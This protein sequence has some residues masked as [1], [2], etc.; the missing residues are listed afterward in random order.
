MISIIAAIGKNR[1]LGKNN[2]LIFRIKEDMAFFKQ[3]TTGHAV[4]MGKKTFDSIGHPLPNRQ[5][6]IITH[7]PD[8]LPKDVT[9]I[10]DLQKF[11]DDC[12]STKDEVF[13]IGGA[14]IYEA[15][16]PYATN[17]Y[18]T[19]VDAA[20]DADAFFPEFNPNDYTREIIKKG[21][22]DGLKFTI[23][24]LILSRPFATTGAN[25][26]RSPVTTGATKRVE[27]ELI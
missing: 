8:N 12:K 27:K 18:L 20:K 21:K 10:T 1:E 4:L 6:Y 3:T 19:E 26:A 5:N 7:H 11:L 14:S 22:E 24:K 9:A 2:A 13:V 17:L 25:R 23:S 15:A 16:L